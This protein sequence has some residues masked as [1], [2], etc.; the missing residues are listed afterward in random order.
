MGY[1]VIG[2]EL[3]PEIQIIP[4]H[5]VSR[6]GIGSPQDS[7]DKRAINSWLHKV[8]DANPD[9]NPPGYTLKA[10]INFF[11]KLKH[12]CIRE[13]A[14]KCEYCSMLVYLTTKSQQ[15]NKLI[16]VKYLKALQKDLSKFIRDG[17]DMENI[18]MLK[19]EIKNVDRIFRGFRGEN[20]S[21]EKNKPIRDIVRQITL[22][23]FQ[24]EN[25]KFE[26]IKKIISNILNLY[27][28]A[29]LLLKTIRSSPMKHKSI[30][31]LKYPDL[32]ALVPLDEDELP[33]HDNITIPAI[34]S[35]NDII[36]Q[37]RVHISRP[38]LLGSP[39]A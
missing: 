11:K 37:D 13:I 36:L 15:P 5:S 34:S 18:V 35:D 27:D 3:P 2:D 14:N 1:Q 19:E 10:T 7:S 16:R 33:G 24:I 22:L 20:K 8:L 21:R 31:E 25:S 39:I 12:C 28:K 23:K 9:L 4:E 30:P 6:H 32:P 26:N 38:A 17:Y 29:I